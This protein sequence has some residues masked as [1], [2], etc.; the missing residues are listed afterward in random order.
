MTPSF[1][2]LGSGEF[3]PWSHEV[4]ERSLALAVGDGSAL[5][6]PTA[7]ATEGDRVFERWATMGLEHYAEAGV[8][9]E[10]L[11]VRTRE[12]AMRPELADRAESA[13]LL[14]FSG[15]KPDH[16]ADVLRDTPL[17]AAVV[18]ALERGAVY[19]GCSAGAMVASQAPVSSRTRFGTSWLFGLGLAPHLSFGVHWD[20]FGRIP[21]LK[22]WLGSHLPEGS[23]FV[24]IEERTAILGEGTTWEIHGLGGVDV[25]GPGPTRA[26]HASGERFTTPATVS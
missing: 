18:R 20:R 8:R 25:R 3:E 16:L 7:S 21:G 26:H 9:A 1:L 10:L 19:A 4:E 22:G 13:S 23:W 17:F 11:P 2:L 6:I 12:D 24:G 15:G 14:F 5:V